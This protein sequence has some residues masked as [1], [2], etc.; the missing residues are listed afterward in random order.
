MSNSAQAL[1]LR[2]SADTAPA[3]R[4]MIDLAKTGASQMALLA[5]GA[6]AAGKKIDAETIGTLKRLAL[7]IT[8]TQL[9]YAAIGGSLST[10]LI[11]RA[12]EKL[13][14]YRKVAAD[15]ASVGVST[16]FF[17][18]FTQSAGQAADSAKILEAALKAAKASTREGLDGST[19][20]NRIDEF[21]R[22]GGFTAAGD[23][24][25]EAYKNAA[26]TEEKITTAIR[27]ID[28]LREI[29]R[30]L[31]A[32]DLAA[33]LFGQEAADALIARADKAGKSLAEM[34][35]TTAD[36]KVVS[37]EQIEN[38][39][40]LEE[41]LEAARKTMSEGMRPIL[42]DLERL[43]T[44]LYAGW[45]S[46]EEVIAKAVATTGSLYKA[47]RSVVELLPNATANVGNSLTGAA[48]A[49][50][51]SLNAQISS[52]EKGGFDPRLNGLRGERDK[53][54]GVVRAAQGADMLKNDAVPAVPFSI[55]PVELGVND[56]LAR[57]G[58]R[59][60]RRP[61]T[62]L[63]SSSPK[64][65]GGGA[66]TDSD[67]EFYNKYVS[68]IEKATAALKTEMETLGLSTFER[69][70]ATLSS[71][72]YAEFKAKDIELSDEQKAKIDT[73]IEAQAR[74]KAQLEDTKNAMQSQREL[75]QFM[76]TNIA[77][78]F[79]DIISGGKNAQDAMMN[80]AKRIADAG[81]QAELLG[82]GPLA[83]L[84]GTKDAAGGVGGLI[85]G[86]FSAFKGFGG[87]AGTSIAAA[88]FDIGSSY[89]PRDML[90]YVHAG[91]KILT[92]G[93]ANRGTAAGQAI[94]VTQTFDFRGADTSEGRLA[95]WG[96]QIRRQTIASIEGRRAVDP[97]YL[98]RGV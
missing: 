78:L 74:L 27:A 23:A 71:K 91:E 52:L 70:K 38:A 63:P 12:A 82:Q 65:G 79:S 97:G 60:P 51:A 85:G 41:R 25:R 55:G 68:S 84:F 53:L 9:L 50:L 8:S 40:Q 28:N 14:E 20:G 32:A 36:K 24:A 29:G 59:P 30:T 66:S 39:R 49:R 1:M 88:K 95:A 67:L 18:K 61:I 81:L 80:L 19:V 89:V 16:D 21:A 10:V 44:A 37:A 86:L 72:A 42:E 54:Q 43:G 92:K 96:E 87:S 58:A 57:A 33:K 94:M 98:G 76:G 64:S 11:E 3:Q 46:T 5:A 93:E 48:E 34:V 17:Q 77:S 69:E 31:E 83:A 4:A 26:S 6:A 15:A 35:N 90:A 2:F 62:D 45:V 73:L 7:V 47:V 13:K 22:N 56:P 75:L